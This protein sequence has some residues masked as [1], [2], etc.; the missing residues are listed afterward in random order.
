MYIFLVDLIAL[1]CHVLH[2]HA[3]ISQGRAVELLLKL[4]GGCFFGYI[5]QYYDTVYK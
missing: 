3:S 4:S 5:D 1:T 2:G